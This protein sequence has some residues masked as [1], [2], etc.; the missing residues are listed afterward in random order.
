VNGPG[1]LTLTSIVLFTL[2]AYGV[3]AGAAS[4][5]QSVV[6]VGVFAFALFV[7]GIVWPIVVLSGVEID[8]WTPADAT[9]G[10]H[11]EVHVQ[12]RGRVSRVELRVLE[13]PGRFWMTA[14]PTS[15]VIPRVASHR[16]VI[17]NLRIEMRTS[18][19][20]GVF[21]RSRVVR[22]QLPIELSVAPQPTAVGSTPAG[23]APRLRERALDGVMA[24][25]S[26]PGLAPGDTVRAVRPYVPGDAARLVHWPSSARRG[27]LVVRDHEPPA[28][29]G[30]A[31][32]VDLNGTA[33]EAEAAA[34]RAAGMGRA[35]FAAGAAVWC[36]TSEAR[37]PMSARV[38]DER[39][40]G[41]RL[42]RAEPGEL[43]TPPAGWPV[44]TVRA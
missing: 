9:V 27:T 19:P 36:C 39:E 7:I 12:M 28:A 16:G 32:V 17:R 1:E 31:I 40:L 34:S 11:Y 6:A 41:R 18:A 21:V 37:G 38:V 23:G 26:T 42:A 33:E 4:G 8:A 5:E 44:E 3:A 15:G 29:F 24:I 43:G 35:L 13:P 10:E 25:T 20:M 14:S 30:V 2:G 22:V